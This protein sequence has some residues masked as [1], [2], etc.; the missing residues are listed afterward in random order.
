[1]PS[2]LNASAPTDEAA[3]DPVHHKQALGADPQ[4][5]EARSPVSLDREEDPAKS[6]AIVRRVLTDL[7]RALDGSSRCCVQVQNT[8][9]RAGWD[10]EPCTARWVAFIIGT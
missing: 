3:D 1:M 6:A 10:E 9:K 2:I 5:E 4:Q 8:R 7:E